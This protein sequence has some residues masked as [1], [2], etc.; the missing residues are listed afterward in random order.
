MDSSGLWGLI[1]MIGDSME[2]RI[3]NLTV[4]MKREGLTMRATGNKIAFLLLFAF[5]LF[6]SSCAATFKGKVIDADTKEPIEGAV[7]VASWREETATIAGPSTRLK[8]VK[9]TLTDKNGEWKIEGP[10]GKRVDDATAMSLFLTGTYVTIPP[11]FI[12]FK[13]GYCSWSDSGFLINACKGKLKGYNYTNSNNIGELI[14]LPKLTEREDRRR[15]KPAPV[16]EKTD[17]KKQKILIQMIREEWQYL[18]SE[19]PG[20]LYKIEENNNETN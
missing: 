5:I 2:I 11:E 3:N 20:N 10:K 12:V 16:G 19:N 9:E 8:D 6:T 4:F 1:G 14:E 18:Y 17:W 7:V 13:P 15:N